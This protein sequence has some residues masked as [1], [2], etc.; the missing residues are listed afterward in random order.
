MMVS[1]TIFSQKNFKQCIFWKMCR[2][3]KY[4]LGL[5][6]WNMRLLKY[7][8]GYRSTRWYGYICTRYPS[9]IW[10][11]GN[12]DNIRLHYIFNSKYCYAKACHSTIAY[13]LGLLLLYWP[14]KKGTVVDRVLKYPFVHDGIKLQVPIYIIAI[15]YIVYKHTT[16]SIY[17][18]IH[19]YTCMM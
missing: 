1:K 8:P 4:P 14:D 6:L 19:L 5:V 3:Q 15:S 16:C 11:S 10:N 18:Y 2:V 9:L 17:T 12:C 7:L 13:I